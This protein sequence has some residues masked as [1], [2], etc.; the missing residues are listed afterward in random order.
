MGVR[1]S[2]M[3]VLTSTSVINCVLAMLSRTTVRGGWRGCCGTVWASGCM[4]MCRRGDASALMHRAVCFA[5]HAGR[6]TD[7]GIPIAVVA[8]AAVVI[9]GAVLYF[10]MG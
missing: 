3:A 1:P 6:P 9:V 10:V 2:L 8:V 4:C 5:D 7:A